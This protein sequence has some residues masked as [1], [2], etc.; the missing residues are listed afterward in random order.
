MLGVSN[1][2]IMII[3]LEVGQ[4][5]SYFPI[6]INARKLDATFEL[7][8]IGEEENHIQDRL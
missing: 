5:L 7:L 1:I 2:L 6:E 3:E 8:N 4:T